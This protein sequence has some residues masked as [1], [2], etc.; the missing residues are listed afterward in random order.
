MTVF[1]ALLLL[2]IT[3][4]NLI[5]ICDYENQIKNISPDIY[6]FALKKQNRQGDKCFEKTKYTAIY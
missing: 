3:N 5:K 1:R 4:E 6:T 2:P